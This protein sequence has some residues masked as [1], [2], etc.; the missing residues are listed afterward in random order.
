MYPFPY[1]QER[2]FSALTATFQSFFY[3]SLADSEEISVTIFNVLFS[4]VQSLSETQVYAQ[5]TIYNYCGPSG[6]HIK[7]TIAEY[8]V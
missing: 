5:R 3:T 2:S 6:I 8:N 1:I 4:V 7:H